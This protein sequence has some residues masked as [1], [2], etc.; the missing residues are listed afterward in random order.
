MGLNSATAI[1][2]ISVIILSDSSTL[3]VNQAQRWKFQNKT[4]LHCSYYYNRY[5]KCKNKYASELYPTCQLHAPIR[6]S[7]FYRKLLFESTSNLFIVAA[8]ETDFQVMSINILYHSLKPTTM[9]SEQ[10]VIQN[11]IIFIVC[12]PVWFGLPGLFVWT[13]WPSSFFCA[14]TQK[15]FSLTERKQ[16]CL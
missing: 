14:A 8:V 1:L 2:V 13:V 11:F 10:H 5:I 16:S 12:T 4:V 7:F 6:T 3:K 15:N 9:Q